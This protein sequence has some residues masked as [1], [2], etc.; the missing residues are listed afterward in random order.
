MGR[1]KMGFS[2]RVVLWHRLVWAQMGV[3]IKWTG[4]VRFLSNSG[5]EQ[6]G[7]VWK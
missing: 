4:V 3:T 5:L 1:M 2:V 6:C 7:L